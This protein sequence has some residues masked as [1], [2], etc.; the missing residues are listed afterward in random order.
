MINSNTSFGKLKEVVVGRE[1]SLT[2]RLSDITFRQF[3]REALHEKIY[4]SG[5]PEGEFDYHVNMDLIDQ[6]NEELDEMAKQIEGLG[7][8]VHRPDALNKITSF[9]TPDFSSELSSASNVR[10]LT[11]VYQNKIIETPT[12]VRNRYFENTLLHDVYNNAFDKGK[13][14]QWIRCPHTKLTEDTIDLDHWGDTR[15]YK[16]FDRNKYVMAIDGAQFLRIGEDVIVNINS[17]NQWAGFE[18]IKS[19]FPETNFHVLHIADNHIDGVIICLK[20]GVFM[21]NP[22]YPNIRDLMPEKF[23][24]WDYLYPKDLTKQLD[25]TGMTNIDIQL[26]SSRGMDVNVLSLDENTVMVNNSAVGVKELLDSSGFNVIET[27]LN[28]GEIFA[29]GIHCSTL[30]LVREDEF[31]SY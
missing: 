8:T 1:L 16:N 7:I 5:I 6:R 10:D 31:I 9:K 3:Y 27:T 28:H 24:G 21:V 25:I 17:Y 14:G 18:W 20:P 29:G 19:F 11:L 30:D 23:K 26:A 15:D 12:F 22:L 4:D 2:K 13:G